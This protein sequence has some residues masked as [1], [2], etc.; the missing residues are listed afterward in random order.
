MI[1]NLLLAF[2]SLNDLALPYMEE[3]L[4]RYWRTRTLRSADKLPLDWSF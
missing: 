4:V 3:L 2:K 1:L